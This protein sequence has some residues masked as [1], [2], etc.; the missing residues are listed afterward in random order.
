M[1]WRV[2][3]SSG[4]TIRESKELTSAVVSNLEKETTI[5]VAEVQGR[6]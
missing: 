3:G 2:I 4:A 6:R 1:Q 5:Y